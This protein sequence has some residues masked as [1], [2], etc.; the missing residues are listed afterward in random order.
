MKF[1]GNFNKLCGKCHNSSQGN[2]PHPVDMTPSEGKKGDIPKSF[3]LVDG[4]VSCKTC[5]DLYLQ[6]RESSEKKKMTSLRGAPYK[7]RTDFCFNCHNEKN[8]EMQ[9][10]HDQMDEKGKIYANKCLYCHVKMPDPKKDEFKDIK[11]VKNMESVCQ[12]CHVIR[13][14]HSGNFNHM[15]KPSDKYLSI[16]AK[17]EIT[18]GIKMPLDEKGKMTCMTCH[19]PHEKGVIPADRPSAKGADS[20]YRHRLPKIICIECHKL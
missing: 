11:L 16:M 20:K 5:H 13:G 19:N 8:Y 6:C 3:P 15:I 14:N 9:D 2:Y 18:F 4:K 1:E 12:G 7:Q 17:M 10:A